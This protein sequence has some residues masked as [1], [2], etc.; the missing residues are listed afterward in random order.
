MP[1]FRA[2]TAE[3]F[4]DYRVPVATTG[5]GNMKRPGGELPPPGPEQILQTLTREYVLGCMRRID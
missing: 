1:L 2:R 5:R 4:G 3:D